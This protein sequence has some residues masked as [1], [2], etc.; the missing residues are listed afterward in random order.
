MLVDDMIRLSKEAK[1]H[2]GWA[3][4]YNYI[5]KQIGIAAKL[6]RW[7]YPLSFGGC[8]KF[9]NVDQIERVMVELM[10]DGFSIEAPTRTIH[11]YWPNKGK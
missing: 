10:E 9:P 6:G 3:F 5:I 7:E 8:E 11:W 2:E 1:N 4:Y